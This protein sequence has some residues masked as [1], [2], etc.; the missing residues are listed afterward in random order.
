MAITVDRRKFLT[1]IPAA[2][3]ATKLLLADSVNAQAAS[4]V[5]SY[6]QNHADLYVKDPH[7]AALAWFR[8]AKWGLFMHYGLY[9]QLGRGEWVM[10]RETIPVTEYEKLAQ[11]YNPSRF[12]ADA[13]T[14]MAIAAGMKYVN[15]TVKH[16]EGF[17]LFHTKQ[18][19]YSAQGR[20]VVA[21]LAKACHKK[22][23][24]IFLY[25]SMSA[26]WHHPYFCDPSA[27]W[28]YFRPAYKEKPA[29]YKWQKDA[30]FKIY[31]DYVHRQL[32]ELLTQYGP[33]AGIWF[34]P[35]AGFYARPDLFPMHETYKLIRSLQ[36]QCLVSFKQGAN[37]EEDFGAPER[38][39]VGFGSLSTI[40]PER[41]AVATQ[42]I[43]RVAELNRNKPTEICNTMQPS[44]WGYTKTNDGK[45]HTAPEIAKMAQDAWNQR[46]NL[47]LNTGPLPDGSISPED[48]RTLNT[49]K[50]YL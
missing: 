32:R 38:G 37:G 44:A 21:D 7:A 5:P 17:C 29:Q 49:V 11:T 35:V 39:S 41:R 24:G 3:A 20:D 23:L 16:H 6:L 31:I 33:V 50:K 4:A 30:D 28:E 8:E 13:I 34:D 48:V 25:Y 43:D 12:D 1:L 18:T 47:L 9:S 14:D 19:P 36:P 26:D 27:G 46:S 45:H 2:A 42:T 40:A 15:L 10:Q 22:G